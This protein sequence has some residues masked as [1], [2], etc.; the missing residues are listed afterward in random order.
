[1]VFIDAAHDYKS[2]KKDI[3]WC[4]ACGC[5]VIC[6]HDYSDIH[7]GVVRAVDEAFAGKIVVQG[8]VWIYYRNGI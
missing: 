7:P 2:V 8:S 4:M 1:M 3:E 6:G 5:P